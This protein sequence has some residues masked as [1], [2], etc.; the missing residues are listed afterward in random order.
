M[1]SQAQNHKHN[2]CTASGRAAATTGESA[3]RRRLTG[4]GWPLRLTHHETIPVDVRSCMSI[5]CISPS[6]NHFIV[7][8]PL[9]SNLRPTARRG[10]SQLFLLTGRWV[11]LRSMCVV[12]HV[13]FALCVCICVCVCVNHT[14]VY[15]RLF[16]ISCV[17]VCVYVYIY[18]HMH[19]SA[20]SE[21]CMYMLTQY[22][23]QLAN[24]MLTFVVCHDVDLGK[25]HRRV[26][27]RQH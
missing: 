7:G 9:M 24:K 22:N 25:S 4:A 1:Y 27:L 21:T 11:A 18:T 13:F 2:N 12:F 16:M 8:K 17:F 6:R 15:L 19:I 5:S 3:V 23:K 10:G 26:A 14:C 20:C